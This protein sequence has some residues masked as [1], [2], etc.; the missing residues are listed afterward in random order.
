MRTDNYSRSSKDD[1]SP[2]HIESKNFLMNEILRCNKIAMCSFDIPKL[3]MELDLGDTRPDILFEMSTGQKVGAEYQRSPFSREELYRKLERNTKKGIAT[4]YTFSKKFYLPL[5]RGNRKYI[6]GNNRIVGATS[7]EENVQEIWGGVD[8]VRRV[9]G[10]SGPSREI[11]RFCL[12]EPPIGAPPIFHDND[13]QLKTKRAEVHII[14]PKII[15][16]LKYNFLIAKFNG[17]F[18]AQ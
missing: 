10:A 15:I 18:A 5:F 17:P 1:E 6:K 4:L 11:V 2:D 13:K 9:W 3:Y 16:E 12:Y 8:C 14:E 7:L